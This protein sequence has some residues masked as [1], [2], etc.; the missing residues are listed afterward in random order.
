M[1][2]ILSAVIP[3]FLV[4]GAAF[5]IRKAF[6]LD[7]KTLATLNIYFFLPALVFASLTQRTIEWTLFGKYVLGVVCMLAALSVLL[8]A[9]ARLRG[10][11][12]EASSA[13]MLSMFPNLGNFGLPVCAFAFGAEGLALAVV[14]MV[15]GSI[16]QNTLGV[17]Y[18]Q[19]SRHS[20]T[21]SCARVFRFPII[22]AFGLALL[23]QALG[24]RLPMDWWQDGGLAGSLAYAAFRAVDLTAKGTIPVQLV[25]LG[26]KL[27][28]TRL[29]RSADVFLACGAR[30]VLSPLVAFGV[31]WLVGIEGL[32][33]K[34]FIL[35]HAAPVAVGMAVYGVQFDV[36]PAFLASLVSWSFLFSLATVSAVL[37]LLA[38]W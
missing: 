3:V 31:V 15:C 27:A 2:A 5:G 13:F 1:E 7:A 20:M 22:Y 11:S 26:S 8:A 18:A 38:L 28:E 37:A 25:I 19:R 12:A 30:L 14:V 34:V 4:A 17:Y 29:D 6:H 35:Q 33:A 24:W 9:V 10:L 32:P 36:R 23:F 16:G 21:S